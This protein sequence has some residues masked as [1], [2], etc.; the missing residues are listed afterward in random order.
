MQAKFVAL[1]L[2]GLV[3]GASA[4]RTEF[5]LICRSS[6]LAG[7]ER[8]VERLRVDLARRLFC[9]DRCSSLRRIASVTPSQI[10]LRNGVEGGRHHTEVS[11][12]RLGKPPLRYRALIPG[13]NIDLNGS[14]QIAPFSGFPDGSPLVG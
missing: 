13:Q 10:M 4:P 3:M 14:C 2:S 9:V 8:I 1:V 5:D 12:D 7:N 6:T 11:V